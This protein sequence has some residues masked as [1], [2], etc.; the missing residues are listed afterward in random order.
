MTRAELGRKAAVV[1]L[2]ALASAAALTVPV[3]DSPGWSAAVVVFVM[4]AGLALTVL[5]AADTPPTPGDINRRVDTV[6]PRGQ[7]TQKWDYTPAGP[8][9][10]LVW[11]GEDPPP[12]GVPPG[13]RWLYLP[14]PDNVV[15]I[16]AAPQGRRR[17]RQS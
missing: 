12:R 17:W 4:A 16:T 9:A 2:A 6:R 13:T 7:L 8:V 10:V 15:P 11:E 14:P 3:F 1:C 5:T